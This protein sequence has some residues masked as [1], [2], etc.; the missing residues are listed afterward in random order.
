[1]VKKVDNLDEII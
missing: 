1:M